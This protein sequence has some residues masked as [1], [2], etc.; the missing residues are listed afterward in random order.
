MNKN[1]KRSNELQR[2]RRSMNNNIETKKYEKTINGFIMRAYRNM[3]SRITGVQKKKFHLYKGKD[4]LEKEVFYSFAK[5]D[6]NFNIL[7]KIYKE[8]GYQIRLCPSV[9]RINPNLG[10]TLE[11]IRFIEQYKNSSNTSR[12]FRKVYLLNK[13]NKPIILFKNGKY[14]E[15]LL[16]LYGGSICMSIKRK[17]TTNGLKF[18]YA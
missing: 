4:L 2:I 14:A 9:D 17:G 12:V 8:S 10:Y 1:T 6:E 16:G 13:E 5:A 18:E 3:K 11:N 7:F 15:K